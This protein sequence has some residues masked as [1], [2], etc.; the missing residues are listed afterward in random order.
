MVGPPGRLSVFLVLTAIGLM[1]MATYYLLG[2]SLKIYFKDVGLHFGA[3]L[4]HFVLFFRGM[5]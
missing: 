1:I 2:L 3:F 5:F 4:K